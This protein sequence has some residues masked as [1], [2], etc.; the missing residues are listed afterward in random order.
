MIRVLQVVPQF[1]V[2]GGER[3]AMHLLLNLAPQHFDVMGVCLEG[4][5]GSEMAQRL[6]DARVEVAYLGKRPGFDP[7]MVGRVLAAVNRFKPDVVH[8]HNHVLPYLMPTL[9]GSKHVK[10]AVHT[11]H[12]LAGYDAIGANRWLNLFAFRHLGV[13]P[14]AIANAVG[15]SVRWVYGVD[16]PI[17]LNGIPIQEY[18]QNVEVRS[19]WRSRHGIGAEDIIFAN[20]ACLTRVKNHGLLLEAFARITDRLPSARCLIVGSGRLA[21]EIKDKVASL[22]LGGQVNLLGDRTDVP[23]ILTA[24]DICVL[25]SD[26]EGRP[27][28][29]M[30]AMAAGKP[31]VATA[32][33]GL[34]EM[35]PPEVG[36]LV[37][38]SDIEKL[39][40]AMFKIAVGRD[41][42]LRMGNAA[43]AFAEEHF[44]VA[45][46][47]ESYEALYKSRLAIGRTRSAVWRRQSHT[48][49]S[50]VQS[51]DTDAH[52]GISY[53]SETK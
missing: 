45:C 21:S 12:S 2:G 40:Q 15:E 14:V 43:R 38:A 29:V 41:L 10:V 39:A 23:E 8:S 31:V 16:A 46:M 44:S 25:S 51:N 20:I 52:A 1:A 37:P 33:G 5:P 26:C 19:Q 28:C 6:A 42:R 34:P 7:R 11:V 3:V 48:D 9:V 30:E 32:V 27:L 22:S 47:T 4:N 24:A 49:D 36:I 50:P 13:M 17:V 35:V 18:Q 53:R